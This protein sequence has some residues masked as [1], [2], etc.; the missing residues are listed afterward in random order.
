M[1]PLP[2]ASRQTLGKEIPFLSS[3]TK[4]TRQRRR[5]RHSGAVT[6]AFLCRV[7]PGTW[8]SLCR[9]LE[10]RTR[11]RRLCRCTVRR[12]LFAECDTRQSL[13]R[14]FSRLCR[15]L[16]ALGKEA[17]GKEVDSGSENLC[18]AQFLVVDRYELVL[19]K[20]AKP[21]QNPKFVRIF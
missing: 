14:V 11:Q 6:A 10:K 4:Y 1:D 5:L 20:K 19:I 9:V 18:V 12:A 21:Q 2:S 16:Q 7:L 17:L 8:Q 15:V 13:C 3:V